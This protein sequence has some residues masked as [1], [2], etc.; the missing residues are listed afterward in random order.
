METRVGSEPAGR[1]DKA[2]EADI[3]HGGQASTAPSSLYGPQVA[4]GSWWKLW[5]KASYMPQSPHL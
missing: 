3:A 5:L 4:V 1:K 2:P